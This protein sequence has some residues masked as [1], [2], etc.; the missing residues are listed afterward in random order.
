[1]LHIHKIVLREESIAIYA[2]TE[3]DY[4]ILSVSRSGCWITVFAEKMERKYLIWQNCFDRFQSEFLESFITRFWSSRSDHGKRYFQKLDFPSSPWLLPRFHFTRESVLNDK[5]LEK[6]FSYWKVLSMS[7]FQ[8][9]EIFI[10]IYM[11]DWSR[12][13]QYGL[14]WGKRQYWPLRSHVSEEWPLKHR[15]G[16]FQARIESMKRSQKVELK[17]WQGCILE[18]NM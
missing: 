13:R 8:F 16:P 18:L 7:I 2:I 9:F 15:K 5:H 3:L 14:L 1:M 11:F 17:T 12:T 4:F 6:Y 10:V